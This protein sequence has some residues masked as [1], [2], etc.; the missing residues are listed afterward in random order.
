MNNQNEPTQEFPRPESE[1]TQAA[2]SPQGFD[3]PQASFQQAGFNPPP[4]QYFQQG[5]SQP[6]YSSVPAKRVVYRRKLNISGLIW[7]SLWAMLACYGILISRGYHIAFTP[8]LIIGLFI[9]AAVLIVVAFI[10]K[11]KEEKPTK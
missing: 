11:S 3:P 10:P 1:P 4:G 5:F 2:S 8:L 9:L 7:M 6:N